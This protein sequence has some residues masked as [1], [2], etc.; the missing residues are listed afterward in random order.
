MAGER[1]PLWDS[2]ARGV[3]FGLSYEK[4]R[5]HLIRAIME[6]C[7]FALHHNLQIAESGGVRVN[8]L[9]S[10]G[11]AARS[12]L[13]TQIKADV[14]G[15]PIIFPEYTDSAPLGAAI[16]AG[17]GVGVYPGFKEAVESTVK[18]KECIEPRGKFHSLYQELFKIYQDLYLK[19]KEDFEHLAKIG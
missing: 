18:V 15:K 2:N 8:V 17:V 9:I 1:S 7:A 16:L 3:F 14:T 12:K 10:V 19:L 4:T 5:A 13:W 11:G 6:G